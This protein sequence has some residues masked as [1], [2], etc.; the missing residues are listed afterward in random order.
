[1]SFRGTK[2]SS[3][4]NWI[5]DIAVLSKNMEFPFYP[6]ASVHPG[7]LYVFMSHQALLIPAVPEL[8]QAYPEY[9]LVVVGHS[10]GGA[11]A[12]MFAMQLYASYNI[13][14]TKLATFGCPRVGNGT[15]RSLFQE[16][17]VRHWRVTHG[18]DP[19]PHLPG[20][21]AEY[22]HVSQEIWQHSTPSVYEACSD[23]F[24]EDPKCS[25]SNFI[26]VD[27]NAHSHYMDIFAGQCAS[28][29]VE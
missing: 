5:E 17:Q 7:F 24:A 19:V 22:I 25:N 14:K 27:L 10:L 13:T 6:S 8:V 11:S 3:L 23:E 15:F 29:T 18:D 16:S 12:T 1:V 26:Y 28:A 4:D 2:K 21:S 20:E 9:D